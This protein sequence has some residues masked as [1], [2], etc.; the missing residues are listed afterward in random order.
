LVSKQASKAHVEQ[1]VS[2]L[3]A[4]SNRVKSPVIASALISLYSRTCS[5][6]LGLQVW[7]KCVASDP[8][9]MSAA[10][11]ASYCDLLG[12]HW[13]NLDDVQMRLASVHAQLASGSPPFTLALATNANVWT[14]LLEA[15]IR[16]N[17]SNMVVPVLRDMQERLRGQAGVRKAVLTVGS[18]MKQKLGDE[19]W[20]KQVRD[21]IGK[22]V[23]EFWQLARSPSRQMF[24]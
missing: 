14:S 17:L 3:T 16:A 22:M 9:I 2:A 15:V 11:A 18:M 4:G 10:M 7:D 12:F 13:R 23:N 24:L 5:P 6:N 1:L 8:P 20:D 19:E 21:E